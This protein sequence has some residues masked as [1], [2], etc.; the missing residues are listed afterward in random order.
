MLKSFLAPLRDLSSRQR[1][2]IA[3]LSLAYFFALMSYPIIRSSSDAF[4]IQSYGAKNWPW[5]TF[6]SV[7]I[8]SVCIFFFDRIQKRIGVKALY[9]AVS[10]FSGLF[11]FCSALALHENFTV[12]AYVTYVW[13]EA[14]VVILIHLCLAFFNTHFSYDFAK[15]F[16]GPFAAISTIGAILGGYFVYYTTD[17]IG[18]FWLIVSGGI[19]CLI[20]P[21]FFAQ[22]SERPASVSTA[23]PVQERPLASLQGIWPYV[24]SIIGIIA[25][26]QL[27]ITVINFRFNYAVQENFSSITGKAKFLGKI[28]TYVNIVSFL[29]Q[30][31]LTP[32]ILRR[33][34]LRNGHF[35]VVGLYLLIFFPL[36]I[37]QGHIIAIISAIYITSKAVDY[38]FFGVIKEML[39][40]PLDE[41]QK[42]GAKYVIDMV[43]Y[44]ASKGGVSLFLTQVQNF[45]VL[46]ALL[47]LSSGIWLALV[48]KIFRLRTQIMRRTS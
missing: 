39:Y 4:F 2:D 1:R 30:L 20:T 36:L 43:M 23:A 18:M 35:T 32:F 21:L 9:V 16:L 27:I 17:H 25:I 26:T 37:F 22:L 48:F 31:V 45:K 47:I 3:F 14:Y 5:V 42:Y 7:I 40:Y 29:I 11:F 41:S 33:I 10:L 13:K 19:S 34:S 24:I 28:Y 15:S 8:L 6:Y 44:R 38:S 12:F 46:D